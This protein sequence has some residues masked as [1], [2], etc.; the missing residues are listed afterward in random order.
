MNIPINTESKNKAYSVHPNFAIRRL[1]I[2]TT[3]RVLVASRN[4]SPPLIERNSHTNLDP[5]VKAECKEGNMVALY[6][7]IPQAITA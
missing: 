5:V 3:T 2:E 4:L 7:V 6:L 1:S